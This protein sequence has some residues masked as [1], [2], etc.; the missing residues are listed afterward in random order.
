MSVRVLGTGV[1]LRLATNE[2]A[3]AM[4]RARRGEDL[5]GLLDHSFRYEEQHREPEAGEA[6]VVALAFVEL[7]G[8]GGTSQRWSGIEHHGHFVP[9]DRDAT[10]ELL[11]LAGAV[12]DDLMDFLIDMRIAGMGVSRWEFK[13]TP[14]RYELDPA[15]A[16]RLKPLRHG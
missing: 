11:E 7:D 12:E 8:G 13:G 1:H 2:E 5:D 9:L 3:A 10:I 16:R 4:A 15:M 14:R 6:Y